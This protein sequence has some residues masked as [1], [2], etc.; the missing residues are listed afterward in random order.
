MFC[1]FSSHADA[2]D[3][4]PTVLTITFEA[5]ELAPFPTSRIT[6]PI[7]IEDDAVNEAPEQLFFA[8]LQVDD[9]VNFDTVN[10]DVRNF[11]FCIIG[12]NDRK[13]SYLRHPETGT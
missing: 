13:L 1:T 6:V 3:F 5:D 7:K 4:D 12:D 11:S 2:T 8:V 10:N 9:A